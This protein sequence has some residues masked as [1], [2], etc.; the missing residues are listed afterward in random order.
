[1]AS[2]REPALCQL[3]RHTFV[4][5]CEVRTY[6]ATRYVRSR[7]PGGHMFWFCILLFFLNDFSQPYYLDFFWTDFHTVFTVRFRHG[8]RWS[9]GTSVFD[10][11]RDGGCHGK[12]LSLSEISFFRRNS[13]TTRD[14]HMVP[15]KEN[16]GHFVFC[17]KAPP[18]M[19]SGD[20]ESP[21]CF[22]FV[23]LLRVRFAQKYATDL[24]R[25]R[26]AL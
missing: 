22:R 20:P 18:V 23:L 6:L 21:N 10:F 14:S 9:I 16:V 17:R 3:Y 1:M 7:L 8:C 12:Q 13:K 25:R 15:G 19:T 4:S 24:R 11:S 2:P 5:C 26:S